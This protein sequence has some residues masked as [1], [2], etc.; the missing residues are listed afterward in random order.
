[1]LRVAIPGPALPTLLL[2]VR[3]LLGF[4]QRPVTFCSNESPLVVKLHL[5]TLFARLASGLCLGL[6][7]S[8]G[9]VD[10]RGLEIITFQFTL[11]L[12]FQVSVKAGAAKSR[13]LFRSF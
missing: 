10:S 3:R 2:K 7:K 13:P 6:A 11:V 5:S 12:D 9:V 4:E 1:M 8:R